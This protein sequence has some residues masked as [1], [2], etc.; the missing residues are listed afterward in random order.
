[1]GIAPIIEAWADAGHQSLAEITPAQV[2]AALPP[3]ESRRSWAEYGLRSLFKVLKARRLIFTNPTRGMPITAANATAPLPL[4]TAA[5][6][7]A[8]DSADPA[9]ALAVSRVAFHALTAAQQLAGL[10]L[11]TSSTDA[12]T[13]TA[14]TSPWPAR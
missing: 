10:Q 6:R 13:S 12:P 7:Q 2:R 14:G 1:M 4:D 3:N 9:V 8:L 11:P 5:V